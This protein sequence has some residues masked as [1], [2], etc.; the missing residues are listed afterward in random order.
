[1]SLIA[2][3]AA[4]HGLPIVDV[5]SLEAF[6]A[7]QPG[8]PEAKL[9][10]FTGDPVRFPEANDVAVILPELVDAFAGCLGAAIIAREA[11]A[12]LMQRFGVKVL[13]SLVL[14]RQGECL[15]VIAKIQDWSVYLER[16]GGMLAEAAS[17]VGGHA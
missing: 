9:L 11:E 13:P 12:A 14:T 1:M 4:C 6:L 2:Q 10:L 17:A 7:P 16:I 3:V 5:V 15:R 8:E